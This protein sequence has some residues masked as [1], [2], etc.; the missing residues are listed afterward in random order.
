[1]I[2]FALYRVGE[3]KKESRALGGERRAPASSIECS[4]SCSDGGIDVGGRGVWDLADR[5]AA[6]GM[7]QGEGASAGCPT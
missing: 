5:C 1:V 4:S 6:R 3:R 2:S 7:A